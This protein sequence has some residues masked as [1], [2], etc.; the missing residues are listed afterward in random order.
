MLQP[1]QTFIAKTGS[2]PFEYGQLDCSIWVADW[3]VIFF[4][5]DPA[6]EF[7]GVFSTARES[8]AL[9]KGRLIDVYD[10]RLEIPRQEASVAGDVGIVE[11][12]R[13]H[14][15]AIFTGAHWA[16]KTRDAV[17]LLAVEPVAIWGARN[18]S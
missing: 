10:E 13:R 16:I 6:A 17:A 11:L 14:L 3:C 2:L 18:G 4:G 8:A 5:H 7:R 1:L 12:R 15:G 9:F